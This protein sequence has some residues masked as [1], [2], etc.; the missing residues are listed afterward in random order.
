MKNTSS[1]KHANVKN[2]GDRLALLLH[3]H[4]AQI[5]Q[6]LRDIL[7]RK[8]NTAIKDNTYKSYLASFWDL[9]FYL[10]NQHFSRIFFRY[11]INLQLMNQY[12]IQN[13]FHNTWL[14]FYSHEPRHIFKTWIDTC[15]MLE[16]VG[17]S[18]C[19]RKSSSFWE[20]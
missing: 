8:I 13:Y 3:R 19:S 14:W 15:Y 10:H 11:K 12:L 16:I 2:N 9:A 20:P 1:S 17:N 4:V 7:A 18:E 6:T 5:S